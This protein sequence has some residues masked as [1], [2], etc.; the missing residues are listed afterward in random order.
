MKR[1]YNFDI[2]VSSAD[3][4]EGMGDKLTKFIREFGDAEEVDVNVSI[5]QVEPYVNTHAIGF[6]SCNEEDYDDEEDGE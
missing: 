3:E 4:L 5:E 2:T 6:V 1:R